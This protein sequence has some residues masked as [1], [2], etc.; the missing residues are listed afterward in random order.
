VHAHHQDLL[1][2]RAVEDA[3]AAA[4]GQAARG[5]PEE[6]VVQLLRRGLLERIHLAPLGVDPGHHVFDHAVLARRVHGLED[7][8]DRPL[9]LGVQLLLQIVELLQ[10]LLEMALAVFLRLEAA[11]EAGIVVFEPELLAGRTRKRSS[12]MATSRGGNLPGA[13]GPRQTVGGADSA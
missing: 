2:I 4:F 8:Q 3:D 13:A 1:V 9:V 10:P 5:P 12:A 6:V 11:G 7:Q